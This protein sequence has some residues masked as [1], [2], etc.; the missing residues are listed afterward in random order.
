MGIVGK[1]GERHFIKG[2]I[3][4]V[5]RHEEGTQLEFKDYQNSNFK[6]LSSKVNDSAKKYAI[7]F[8]NATG[9]GSIY[10][11]IDD[12]NCVVGL[13]LT[14]KERDQLLN[15]IESNLEHA[16]NPH[17]TLN[18]YRVSR[19]PVYNSAK[20]PIEDL[21]ILEV[22][23]SNPDKSH[24]SSGKYY[25]SSSKGVAYIKTDSSLRALQG[26][27]IQKAVEDHLLRAARVK[28]DAL[29]EKL[30]EEPER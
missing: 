13:K 12:D 27:E 9:F 20:Q 26:T 19:H 24:R 25:L 6:Q 8:L 21:I 18:N 22:T 15:G 30:K 2:K 28:L 3:I 10:F 17:V 5:Q 4:E 29:E 7:G 16:I 14:R 23:I 11:G 1:L